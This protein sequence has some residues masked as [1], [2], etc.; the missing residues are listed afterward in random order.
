MRVISY[1]FNL[2][3]MCDALFHP[4]CEGNFVAKNEAI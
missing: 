4:F 1:L 2:L 3:K